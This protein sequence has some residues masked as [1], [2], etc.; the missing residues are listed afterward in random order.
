LFL[1]IQEAVCEELVQSV[2]G[3]NMKMSGWGWGRLS[4][5]II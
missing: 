1:H 3:N 2:G 4:E 5:E